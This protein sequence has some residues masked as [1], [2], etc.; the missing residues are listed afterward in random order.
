LFGAR[1]KE[2]GVDRHPLSPSDGRIVPAL[3][4]EIRLCSLS[5]SESATIFL[6]TQSA[7]V[8]S[9]AGDLPFM[10]DGF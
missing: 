2:F 8:L 5:R 6:Q 9:M 10:V 4:L 1:S 3:P 7:W